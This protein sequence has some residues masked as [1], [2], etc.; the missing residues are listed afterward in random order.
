VIHGGA[1][2]DGV[3]ATP[4]QHVSVLVHEDKI[5]APDKLACLWWPL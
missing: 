1:L 2:L 3:S 4:Q 5:T